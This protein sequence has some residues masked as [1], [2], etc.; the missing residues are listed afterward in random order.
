MNRVIKILGWG[1]AFWFLICLTVIAA[2]MSA[3]L[4]EN[5]NISNS[6]QPIALLK[7]QGEI[8]QADALLEQV[9]KM[10]QDSTIRG[11]LLRVESPGGTVG[12]SQ[13]IYQAMAEL[14]SDSFPVVAS[15]GN[16]AA[17]GGFYSALPA[18]RIYANPGT[19]TGSIGVVMQFLHGEEVMEKIG[20][21]ANTITS[22]NMK[23]V[24]SP[25]RAPRKEEIDLVQGV[26]A[27]VHDQFA[28]AV[29]LWRQIPR[30]SLDAFADGRILTGRQAWKLGLV[31]SLGS[32]QD[33]LRWLS[34]RIGL[35][36]VPASLRTLEPEEPWVRGFMREVGAEI[37]LAW[38]NR[39]KILWMMP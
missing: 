22:G 30:D 36:S 35:D 11:V 39:A 13:E 38:K 17:S 23:A 31:D 9:H 26:V 33:A 2:S 12:A 21:K 32:Q 5:L 4:Q 25:F 8:V 19:L 29:S 28:E 6:D 18:E 15:F 3:L 14:R 24:G 7:I 37:P 10:R 27:D 16:L 20:L 34:Q 1:M